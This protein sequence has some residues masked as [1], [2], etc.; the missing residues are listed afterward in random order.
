M[1][2][3]WIRRSTRAWSAPSCTWWRRGRTFS[4]RCVCA[5]VFKCR[6]G[7]HIG[8]PSSGSSSILV[9]S[10]DWMENSCRRQ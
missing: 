1:E 8:K 2:S 3:S 5:L 4:F 9:V 7:L 6:R 10:G